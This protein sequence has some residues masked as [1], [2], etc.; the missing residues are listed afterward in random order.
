MTRQ[1]IGRVL[2]WS[3]GW[4][5]AAGAG[6]GMVLHVDA[7][8][9]NDAADGRSA[10]TAWRSLERVNGVVLLAGDRVRLRAG[11]RWSG[12]LRPQGGGRAGAPVVI[13]AYAAVSYTH[14]TLPTIYSV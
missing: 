1:M 14:L 13:E 7:R 11:C 6:S 12:Q 2:A 4:L 5:A 9:G 8:D 3:V 10:A